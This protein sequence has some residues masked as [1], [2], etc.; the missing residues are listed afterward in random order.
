MTVYFAVQDIDGDGRE[1]L[2]INYPG[3]MMATIQEMVYDYDESKGE[4]YREIWDFPE[5]QFMA[6]GYARSDWSHNHTRSEFWPYNLYR[7]NSGTDQYES[8]FIVTAWDKELSETD[9]QGNFFPDAVDTSNAGRVFMIED[10][11]TGE[12]TGPMDTADYEKW[13]SDTLGE[14]ADNPTVVAWQQ[15]TE[16][17]LR[18]L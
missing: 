6:S 13:Y 18:N 1:E 4:L 2:L 11:L 8:A 14:S 7:Y 15:L 5:I 16:E 12:V 17:N 9:A 3:T 10:G